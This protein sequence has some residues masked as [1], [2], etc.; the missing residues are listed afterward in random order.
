[1][2]RRSALRA[3]RDE[4]SIAQEM[5][6]AMASPHE[7]YAVILEELEELWEL[8]KRKQA[9]HNQAAM[10]SEAKQVAAMALRFMIDLT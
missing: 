10:R 8:V 3:V 6:P 2:K 9:H 7:G 5:Y 4:L 1:M